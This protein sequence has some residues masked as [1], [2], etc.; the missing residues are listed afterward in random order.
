MKQ[1]NKTQSI[2]KSQNDETGML[3]KWKKYAPQRKKKK[4]G[5]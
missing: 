2:S 1:G 5:Y 3:G 4:V